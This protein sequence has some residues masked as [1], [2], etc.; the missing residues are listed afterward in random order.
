MNRATILAVLS[1]AACLSPAPVLA[2]GALAV[3]DPPSIAT[4]GFTYGIDVDSST[5]E[6]ARQKAMESCR[7]A[8]NAPAARDLCTVVQSFYHQCAVVAWDPGAGTP[9]VGWA[10]APTQ[11]A[12]TETAMSNCRTT[13]GADRQQ[14]C[15]V[16]L[17]RC[18][19]Q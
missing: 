12:A 7:V 6:I 5:D 18:D 16:N 13:A 3:G 9:G 1:V 15:V 2:Y 8:T 14:F 10:V 11:E 19:T 4:V 17:A